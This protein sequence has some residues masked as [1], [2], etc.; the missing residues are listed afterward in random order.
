MVGM[1]SIK[2]RNEIIVMK[3]PAFIITFIFAITVSMVLIVS[4]LSP[5]IT[6]KKIEPEARQILKEVVLL[7]IGVCSGYI[8]G[9]KKR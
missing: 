4:V 3:D 1:Y 7:M 9:N 2:K 8:A 5:V 6:G